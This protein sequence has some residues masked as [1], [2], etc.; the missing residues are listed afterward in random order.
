[1][2]ETLFVCECE[3]VCMHFLVCAVGVR[4]RVY[5]SLSLCECVSIYARVFDNPVS[6]LPI[7]QETTKLSFLFSL[8]LSLPLSLPCSLSLSLPLYLSR[9]IAC[10]LA[11][12]P[13]LLRAH[14]RALSLSLIHTYS[15]IHKHTY[16]GTAL[17][18][19]SSTK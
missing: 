11:L 2:R 4:A 15:H 18:A 5:L 12:P 3:A 16:T 6:R 7:P 13:S 9:T 1:L 17:T 14:S 10:P 19:V 8:P